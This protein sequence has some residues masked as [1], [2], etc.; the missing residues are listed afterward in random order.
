MPVAAKKRDLSTYFEYDLERNDPAILTI[1]TNIQLTFKNMAGWQKLIKTKKDA[2]EEINQWL[3]T[4]IVLPLDNYQKTLYFSY[5]AFLDNIMT[6]L[7]PIIS[8]HQELLAV[9][10]ATAKM[11]KYFETK[12]ETGY[13]AEKYAA[14]VKLYTDAKD[15][16]SVMK[17]FEINARIIISVCS[18]VFKVKGLFRRRITLQEQL[19]AFAEVMNARLTMLQK[20]L[21][22]QHQDMHDFI[23][24]YRETKEILERPLPKEEFAPV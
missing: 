16:L 19:D 6:E 12:R 4:S 7:S 18:G 24:K 9:K 10:E 21:N 1:L 3:L 14:A 13:T 23:D 20:Q 8:S 22:T 11:A 15:T 5:K 17:Q 2:G